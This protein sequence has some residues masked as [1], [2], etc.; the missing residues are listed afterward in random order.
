[1]GI[2]SL[3]QF[4]TVQT[5]KRKQR[6]N[7]SIVLTSQMLRH[8]MPNL[9]PI[10]GEANA[11]TC[12][13]GVGLV[14]HQYAPG[15][16]RPREETHRILLPGRE[17]RSHCGYPGLPAPPRIV[18]RWSPS[19]APF[20]TRSTLHPIRGCLRTAALSFLKTTQSMLRDL[21][22]HYTTEGTCSASVLYVRTQFRIQHPHG[23]HRTVI[24]AHRQ[25]PNTLPQVRHPASARPRPRAPPCRIP[26]HP[27]RLGRA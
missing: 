24:R 25:P 3:G 14:S 12:S 7:V 21:S 10:F 13:R 2:R 9:R 16:R 8:V 15:P 5:L 17:P 23:V 4:S 19:S 26:T 1:M 11:V 22:G 18:N 20:W 6:D 27:V